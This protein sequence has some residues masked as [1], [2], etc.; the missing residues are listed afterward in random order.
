MA[1]K[2]R[3]S[4]EQIEQWHQRVVTKQATLER[5][6]EETNTTYATIKG[7][8]ARW[9]AR[10][11]ITSTV[12]DVLFPDLKVRESDTAFANDYLSTIIRLQELEKG[13]DNEQDSVQVTV[14][15][16][17]PIMVVFSGDWHLANRFTDHALL[18]EHLRIIRETPGVYLFGMGDYSDWFI[19]RRSSI[20]VQ[21]QVIKPKEQRIIARKL[22]Q[23]DTGGKTLALLAGNHCWMVEELTGEDPVA[24]I[25]AEMGVPYLGFGGIVHLGLGDVRYKGSLWHS[26]PGGSVINP[27]NNQRRVRMDYD[28]ID[29]VCLGHFHYNYM[30]EGTNK[31]G[32]DF[33]D[34]RSGTFKV[35]DP[36][37]SAMKLGV[38]VGDSR[39]PGV[40][41]WPTLD[42]E[43]RK[44]MDPWR[45]FRRGLDY[46][47]LL[48]S[49]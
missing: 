21:E 29:F 27:G 7:L 1:A 44:Q 31:E 11:K 47:N 34:L 42:K 35:R 32:R 26:Y 6:A 30:Q 20:G 37:Y 25:A 3:F 36:R 33:I 43:G 2:R 46:L 13:Q 8:L 40:V 9:R 24:D 4:D 16:T 5:L 39:M 28:S 48:R 45:D 23:E 19:G 22:L 17:K 18:K 38:K 15:D 10:P 14:K 12:G 49:E 41:F